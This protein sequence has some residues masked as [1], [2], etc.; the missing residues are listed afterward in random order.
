MFINGVPLYIG[1]IF[2]FHRLPLTPFSYPTQTIH[3]L[4]LLRLRY[5]APFFIACINFSFTRKT[6]VEELKSFNC[7]RNDRD[8]QEGRQTWCVCVRVRMKLGGKN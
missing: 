2:M 5:W 7:T 6:K 1:F 4:L 3:H 8:R